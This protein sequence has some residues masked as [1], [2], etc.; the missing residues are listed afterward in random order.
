MKNSNNVLVAYEILRDE[1]SS[2]FDAIKININISSDP[3]VYV[4]LQD[5]ANLIQILDEQSNKVEYISK[6]YTDDIEVLKTEDLITELQSDL[7]TISGE[8]SANKFAADILAITDKASSNKAGDIIDMVY[9]KCLPIMSSEEKTTL[10]KNRSENIGKN[11]IKWCRNYLKDA[12]YLKDPKD[13]GLYGYWELTTKGKQWITSYNKSLCNDD[14]NGNH[15]LV[16][17]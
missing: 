14:N 4:D 17:N 5:L 12:K 9:Q 3:S 6:K 7:K 8:N 10:V 1:I 15:S 2:L 16:V 13:D 11:R